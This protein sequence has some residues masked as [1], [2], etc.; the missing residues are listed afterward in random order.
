MGLLVRCACR[1][2]GILAMDWA[3]VI[4]VHCIS[5]W[6]ALG[7]FDGTPDLLRTCLVSIPGVDGPLALAC[8]PSE[9]PVDLETIVVFVPQATPN[10]FTTSLHTP[11]VLNPQ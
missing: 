5:L 11:S 4:N 9:L 3:L 10:R 6:S 8:P 1:F 7:I 2:I